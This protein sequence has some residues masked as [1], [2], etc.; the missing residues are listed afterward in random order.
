MTDSTDKEHFDNLTNTQP[1][2]P[3]D[4]IIPTQETESINTNQEIENMEVHHHPDLHHNPKKWKEYF[5]EFLMIFLAV[6]MGFIAENIRE[7]FVLKKHEKELMVSLTRDLNNDIDGLTKSEITVKRYLN[8]A[9]SI[10]LLFKNADYKNTSGDIYYFGRQLGLRNLWRSNDGTIQQLTYSGGLRLIENKSIIDSIQDYIGTL[11]IFSQILS[12]ED[13]E[14]SE[15][16]KA[17]SKVFSGFV[18]NDM[19]DINK[20]NNRLASRLNYNP[21]LQSI[22]KNDINDLAVQITIVK[23]NRITQLGLMEELKTKASSLIKFIN[24]EY[25]LE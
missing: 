23:G 6:T 14:I 20:Q 15:Y 17:L 3:T 24:K 18:F 12:L 19:I 2:I 7:H 21:D 1:D 9:D 11:K 8:Y 25:G 10:F 13:I 22:A 4:E 16:R 5:L